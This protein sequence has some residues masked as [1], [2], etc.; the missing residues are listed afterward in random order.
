MG[1]A[2][3]VCCGK[4]GRIELLLEAGTRLR[5]PELIEAARRRVEAVAFGGGGRLL[6]ARVSPARD[7][8]AGVLHG[9]GWHRV[10]AAARGAAGRRAVGAVVGMNTDANL[11]ETR[12]GVAVLYFPQWKG[13]IS[14][15]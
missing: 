13:L 11:V 14:L 10:P 1:D 3:H 12:I 2:D 15:L 6:A 7:L 5:R 8:R 9:N 4:L